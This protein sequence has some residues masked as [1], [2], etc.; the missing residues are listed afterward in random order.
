MS[1]CSYALWSARRR[2]NLEIH[3]HEAQRI[4]FSAIKLVYYEIFTR[5]IFIQFCTF[6]LRFVKL[7]LL[8]EHPTAIIKVSFTASLG[9]PPNGNWWETITRKVNNFR[10]KLNKNGAKTFIARFSRRSSS[11]L[12]LTLTNSMVRIPTANIRPVLKFF[13]HERSKRNEKTSSWKIPDG[14]NEQRS[15]YSPLKHVSVHLTCPPMTISF[16][17]FSLFECS[18]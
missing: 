3:E 6:L 16:S 9:N 1:M 10:S 18:W 7:A 5:N 8:M 14:E 11:V 4:A 13:Q 15:P 2:N 17:V 12:K